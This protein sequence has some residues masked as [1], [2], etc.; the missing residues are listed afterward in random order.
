[1]QTDCV[2]QGALRKAS[3]SRQ[4]K[5]GH[6]TKVSKCDCPTWSEYGIWKHIIQTSFRHPRYITFQNHNSYKDLNI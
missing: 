6:C 4:E 1:M 2:Q 3:F 5:H